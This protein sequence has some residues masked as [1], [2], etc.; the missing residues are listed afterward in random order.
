MAIVEKK[1]QPFTQSQL[2]ESWAAFGQTKTNAGDTDRLIL[3]KKPTLKNDHE[4]VFQLAI[5]LEASF[6]ER[7]EMD[8][9]LFLR[10]YLHNDTI[11]IR[12][13]MAEIE[14]TKKLYTV[15]D[16]YDHMVSQNPN[17]KDLKER[18]GLDYDY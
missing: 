11:V 15:S 13:E 9:V 17:L 4:V 16:I 12:H 18:L 6:L 8:I 5:Q 2:N 3:D 1:T 10:K 7:M 14:E